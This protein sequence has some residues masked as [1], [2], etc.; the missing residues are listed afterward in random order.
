MQIRGNFIYLLL[1]LLGFLAFI[2]VVTEYPELGD[3]GLVSFAFEVSLIIAVWSL[4]RQRLWFIIGVCLIV[5]GAISIVLQMLTDSLYA[6]IFG[7]TVVF[8]FYIMTTFIAF[9]ELFSRGPIDLN[10]IFG[11]ICVYLL[12]GLNWAILYYYQSILNHD[13]FNG[14]EYSDLKEKMFNLIYYSYVTLSTLGYG[15]I[16]PNSPIAQVLGVL[17]ALF[18]Q[19]YIAILVAILV[20][21]H[22]SSRRAQ[23]HISAGHKNE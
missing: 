13:A 14:L 12:A 15:D 18:G 4:V 22:I 3:W 2:A 7:I 10:K 6:E 5:L 21:T 16:T 11:S 20:G 19:F 23:N 8:L 9:R 17:E 1:S